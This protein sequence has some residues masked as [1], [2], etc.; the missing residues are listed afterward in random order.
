MGSVRKELTINAKPEDVWD[1]VRDFG[2]LHTRLVPG[3]VTDARLDGS[4]R[5]VTFISGAV[6]REP[7]VDLDDR[8]RRLVYSAV[9]SRWGRRTTTHLSRCSPTG[10]KRAG[11]CGSS[12][13]S[14]TSSPAAL[15]LSWNAAR[16]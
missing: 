14:P 16:R 11:S 9:D 12:T 1:A 5:I 4:D 2:A 6:Q 10:R 13:S 8:A 7:L 3:F 15:T